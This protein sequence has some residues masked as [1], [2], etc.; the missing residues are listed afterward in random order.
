MGL[1]S[2]LDSEFDLMALCG[3]QLKV[4]CVHLSLIEVGSSPIYQLKVNP[5]IHT[6]QLVLVSF[7]F[8]IVSKL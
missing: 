2:S 7:Q 5:K 1:D 8:F 3:P 6:Y 4:E